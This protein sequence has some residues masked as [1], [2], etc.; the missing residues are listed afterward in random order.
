MAYFQQHQPSHQNCWWALCLRRTQG[1]LQVS[2]L[3][4]AAAALLPHQRSNLSQ[5][6]GSSTTLCTQVVT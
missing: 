2:R 4:S 5:Q 1:V 6:S 3:A